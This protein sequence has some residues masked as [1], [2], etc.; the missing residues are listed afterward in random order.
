MRV[1]QGLAWH[2]RRAPRA[3]LT[4]SILLL[5]QALA[6]DPS[7]APP[8]L[9]HFLQDQ[10][11]MTAED[12]TAFESG[13]TITRVLPHHKKGELAVAAA[14]RINVPLEFFVKAFRHL[15]TL[16]RGPQTLIVSE[17]SDPPREADLQSLV[18]EPQ[19]VKDLPQCAPGN[20]GVKLSAEMMQQLTTETAASSANQPALIN[21]VFRKLL[22]EYVTTYLSKGN[23]A[24]MTYADKLPPVRS[25][26]AFLGLLQEFALLRRDAAPLYNCLESYSGPPCPQIENLLYWSYAKFGLKPVLT[27]NDMLTYK[28]VRNGRP[29]DFLAI[30][31]IYADHYFIASLGVVILV[32]QSDTPSEP[33]LWVVYINRSQT[34]GL[35][36]LFGPL[37]RGVV[38]HKSRA[39]AQKDVLELKSS[40]EA[41]YRKGP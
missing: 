31:Q 7:P 10:A 27:V 25:L 37:K 5:T 6:K 34:D 13:Q 23:P 28:T 39:T 18:L 22:F 11:G 33:G 2:A 17:F 16:E 30:K 14:T 35:S 26:D 24:L 40:L 36:G 19:D 4:L 12:L 9:I 20:C 29:W 38:E 8:D 3:P 15:P 1:K 41:Q 32:P 21:S